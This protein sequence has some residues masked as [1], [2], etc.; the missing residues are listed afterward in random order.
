MRKLRKSASGAALLALAAL[1]GGCAGLFERA[2]PHLY[3]LAAEHSVPP[4]PAHTGARLLVLRP[5]AAA[6]LDTTRIALTRPPVALDYFA[7]SAW[8]RPLP[9][10]L[11]SALV[12]AFNASGAVTAG[13]RGR[14]GLHPDFVLETKIGHFEAEYRSPSAP[15]L[16]RVA[17]R[18]RLLRRKG[19]RVLAAVRFSSEKKAAFNDV[20]HIVL[21]LDEA[22]DAVIEKSVRWTAQNPALQKR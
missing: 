20:P 4:A 8:P 3:R 19:E 5:R 17:L 21:A 7:D 22:L 15:P 12:E 6:G 18:L 13:G 16:A 11:Q 9:R 14:L 2:P 10:L 1:L